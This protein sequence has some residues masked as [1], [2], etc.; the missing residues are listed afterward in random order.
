[1]RG[2]YVIHDYKPHR[3]HIHKVGMSENLGRRK[4]EYATHTF[5]PEFS[6]IYEIH[7]GFDLLKVEEALH[8]KLERLGVKIGPEWFEI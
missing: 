6:R 5:E 7:E 8:N 2:I 3:L 4:G 1:M